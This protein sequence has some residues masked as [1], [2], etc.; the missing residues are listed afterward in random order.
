[1][2]PDSVQRIVRISLHKITSDEAKLEAACATRKVGVHRQ[3]SHRCQR[4][5]QSPH[6]STDWISHPC[7]ATFVTIGGRGFVINLGRQPS[8][9]VSFRSQEQAEECQQQRCAEA[10]Q[11]PPASSAGGAWLCAAASSLSDVRLACERCSSNKCAQQKPGQM[12]LGRARR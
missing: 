1:M 9:P 2:Q 3:G 4:G 7:K 6:S 11:A 10:R 8:P 5:C 12:L